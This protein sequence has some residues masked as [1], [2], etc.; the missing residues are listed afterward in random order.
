MNDRRGE[1][2]RVT[3]SYRRL[4]HPSEAA[5]TICSILLYSSY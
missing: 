5:S 4:V 3:T 1:R 2:G